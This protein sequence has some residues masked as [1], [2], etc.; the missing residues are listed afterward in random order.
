[1]DTQLR[2]F[3]TLRSF[4]SAHSEFHEFR[5]FRGE[6]DKSGQRKFMEAAPEEFELESPVSAGVRFRCC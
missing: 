5:I 6:E 3:V 2:S 4:C 1:M